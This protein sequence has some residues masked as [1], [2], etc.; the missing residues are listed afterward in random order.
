MVVTS[1]FSMVDCVVAVKRVNPLVTGQLVSCVHY[2]L[3][4]E[5]NASE[6]LENLE[7]IFS[8]YAYYS[9]VLGKFK[10]IHAHTHTHIH[11][12]TYTHTYIYI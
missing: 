12:R 1:S 11:A 9:D 7:G 8:R 4:Y 5:V 10:Y 6:F 3:N 2:Q